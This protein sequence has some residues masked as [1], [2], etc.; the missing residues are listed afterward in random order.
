MRRGSGERP[1]ALGRLSTSSPN[2]SNENVNMLPVVCTSEEKKKEKIS[3]SSIDNLFSA[4]DKIE[5]PSR[6][7]P[8]VERSLMSVADQESRNLKATSIK[9]M[10]VETGA[11]CSLPTQGRFLSLKLALSRFSSVLTFR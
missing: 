4:P 8:E 10:L 9:K 3:I 1:T 2:R 6:Y 5:I 11:S 7:Q